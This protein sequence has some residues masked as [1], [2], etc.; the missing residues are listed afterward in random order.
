MSF[1]F[2]SKIAYGRLKTK[3]SSNLLH[4]ISCLRKGNKGLVSTVYCKTGPKYVPLICEQSIWVLCSLGPKQCLRVSCH[5][6]LSWHASL[7]QH[8]RHWYRKE[9]EW[10]REREREYYIKC[11]HYDDINFE[12]SE[13]AA[14]QLIYMYVS[15]TFF[16]YFFVSIFTTCINKNNKQKQ[17][18]VSVTH[19][20]FS[21]LVS[22]GRVQQL[23]CQGKQKDEESSARIIRLTRQMKSEM[24]RALIIFFL[25]S[26]SHSSLSFHSF[27]FS[28]SFH[29]AIQWEHVHPWHLWL[30]HSLIL[31]APFFLFASLFFPFR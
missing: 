2:H 9:E 8:R 24:T 1:L 14:G 23:H 15:D 16:C 31:S 28:F 26:L 30:C 11:Q 13:Q 25:L 12:Q 3:V 22:L 29:I 10:E 19:I 4:L 6:I 20:F 5:V 18:V 21:Y 17:N 27:F 7:V